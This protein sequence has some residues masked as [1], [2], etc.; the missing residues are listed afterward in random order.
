[1]LDEA[2]NPSEVLE[3]EALFRHRMTQGSTYHI[4]DF[5]RSARGLLVATPGRNQIRQCMAR[6][7]I[8]GSNR[9]IG[10]ETVKAALL[11]GHNVRALARSAARISIQNPSL[12]KVPGCGPLGKDDS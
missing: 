9:G 7:L 8:I 10:L 5:D 12:E 11:P 1:V 6:V 4:R 2:S 3:S